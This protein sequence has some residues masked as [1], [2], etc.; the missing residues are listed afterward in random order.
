MPRS[1]VPSPF[2]TYVE[3]TALGFATGLRS[4][5]PFA[6]LSLVAYRQPTMWSD[7]FGSQVPWRLLGS[8]NVRTGLELSAVGEL[9]GDKLPFAF[10]R[11]SPPGL[12][13]RCINGA[14]AGATRSL[15]DGRSAWP[16]GAL[17]ALAAAGGAALGYRYR[18][19]VPG[20]TGVPDAIWAV[21]EDLVAIGLSVWSLRR[22]LR[23]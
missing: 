19:T 11:A 6:L 1:S 4:L 17:G 7:R 16:G 20:R 8:P 23:S 14:L 22:F 13:Q 12:A 15:L 5:T 2:V 21:A 18:T 3:A 10:S 9:V